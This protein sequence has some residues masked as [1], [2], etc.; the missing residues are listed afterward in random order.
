MFG[1]EIVQGN[2]DLRARPPRL[3]GADLEA[4]F[5]LKEGGESGTDVLKPDA[6]GAPRLEPRAVVFDVDEEL[7]A[8]V[9]RGRSKA[10]GPAVL[11]DGDARL[12][13]LLVPSSPDI[14]A[15]AVHLA[16]DRANARLPAYAHIESFRLVPPL[17]PASGLVTANG[18]PRRDAIASVYSSAIPAGETTA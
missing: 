18:R 5:V 2:A 12:S 7:R 6:I 16:I 17:T 11:G 9:V 10:D 4:G 3:H 8:V 15:A 14:D 1:L 13:A